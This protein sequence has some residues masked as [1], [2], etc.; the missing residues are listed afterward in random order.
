MLDAQAFRRIKHSVIIINTA[1]GS[2]IDARA[3]IQALR[4][5]KVAAAGLDVLADEPLIRDEAELICSTYCDQHDLRNLLADHLLLR[6]PNVIVTPHSAFNTREA[7]HRIVETTVA[8]I[9]SFLVSRLSA[10]C[11]DRPGTACEDYIGT[12]ARR[13]F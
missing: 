2:V 4:S 12:N 8:N 11:G 3:L 10:K 9:S 5:G 7:V 13:S 6:L 1:R